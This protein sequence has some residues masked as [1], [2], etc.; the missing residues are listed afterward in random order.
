METHELF[1]ELIKNVVFA[2]K[3]ELVREVTELVIDRIETDVGNDKSYKASEIIKICNVSLST[4][5]RWTTKG[6]RYTQ[7]E[8]RTQRYFTIKDVNNFKTLK[9]W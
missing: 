6:L 7:T 3:E 4:L 1:E 8:K 9:K 5:N 2:L